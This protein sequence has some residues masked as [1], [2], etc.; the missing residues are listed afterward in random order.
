MVVAAADCLFGRDWAIRSIL[1]EKNRTTDADLD[2][3]PM[4]RGD[5]LAADLFYRLQIARGRIRM[6]RVA[7]GGHAG[8]RGPRRIAGAHLRF[9][10]FARKSKIFA[11]KPAEV[12]HGAR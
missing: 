11:R 12:R 9:G 8:Q 2:H 7:P 1:A 5:V 6:E 3:L 10:V 4:L